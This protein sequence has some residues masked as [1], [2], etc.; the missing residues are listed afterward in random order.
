MLHSLSVLEAVFV[1]VPGHVSIRTLS[2]KYDAVPPVSV[3]KVVL[4]HS[5]AQHPEVL[6]SAPVLLPWH[7]ER[8]RVSL[9]AN[10]VYALECWMS[11]QQ[12]LI[13]LWKRL[14][15]KYH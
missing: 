9:D 5:E 11:H 2:I 10:L 8:E 14:T 7:H 3:N 15:L 6:Q 13:V 4:F 1:P 12:F